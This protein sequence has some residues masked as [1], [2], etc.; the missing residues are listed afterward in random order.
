MLD[1]KAG[2]RPKKKIVS[3]IANAT[4]E[5]NNSQLHEKESQTQRKTDPHWHLK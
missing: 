5:Q 2:L 3:W 4:Y 1:N